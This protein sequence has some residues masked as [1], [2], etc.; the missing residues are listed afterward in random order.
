[1]PRCTLKSYTFVLQS[2]RIRVEL[3]RDHRFWSIVDVGAGNAALRYETDLAKAV[4]PQPHELLVV[5]V[6]ESCDSS[7]M[8]FLGSIGNYAIYLSGGNP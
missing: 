4:S 3:P 2:G 7:N 8:A 1:M 5:Q 6:G